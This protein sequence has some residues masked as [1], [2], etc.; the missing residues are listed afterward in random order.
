M[1]RGNTGVCVFSPTYTHSHAKRLLGQF[2]LIFLIINA[3][4]VLK[5][6]ISIV[7]KHSSPPL[8]TVP[9]LTVAFYT[10]IITR[11]GEAH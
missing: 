3:N 5:S 10:A 2:N 6:N 8:R 7:A 9:M 11:Y 1:G 4:K